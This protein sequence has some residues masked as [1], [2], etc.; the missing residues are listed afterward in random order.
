MSHA[1]ERPIKTGQN[2]PRERTGRTWRDSI[3]AVSGER[4][5]KAARAQASGEARGTCPGVTA[6]D[7]ERELE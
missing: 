1:A 6:D 2:R 5:Q 7:S 4:Q 3:G